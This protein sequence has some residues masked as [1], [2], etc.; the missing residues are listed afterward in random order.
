[1]L[2]G[3]AGIVELL[4][5]H[6]S[7]VNAVAEKMVKNKRGFYVKAYHYKLVNICIY[8][9]FQKSRLVKDKYIPSGSCVKCNLVMYVVGLDLLFSMRN[10]N[11]DN[12]SCI[13]KVVSNIL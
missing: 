4:L 1:M 3:K 2:S 6:G 11:V 5:K 9:L 12:V 8:I 7:Y 13:W 10:S